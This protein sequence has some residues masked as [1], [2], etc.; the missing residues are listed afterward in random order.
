MTR[1]ISVPASV[2]AAQ[3]ADLCA[4]LATHLRNAGDSARKHGLSAFEAI[5]RAF[6]GNLWMPP[7][8]LDA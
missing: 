6:T 3:T 7:V 2:S 1:R 5:H 8:A 4:F